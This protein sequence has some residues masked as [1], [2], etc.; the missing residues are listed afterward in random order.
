MVE[1][2]TSGQTLTVVGTYKGGRKMKTKRNLLV[3]IMAM[4]MALCAFCGIMTM[5]NTAKADGISGLSVAKFTSIKVDE[6]QIRFYAV[7]DADAKAQAEQSGY[8]FSNSRQKTEKAIKT[9]FIS[10]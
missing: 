7:M 6:P 2:T 8:G 4:V 1:T 5:T 9:G 3:S 10:S